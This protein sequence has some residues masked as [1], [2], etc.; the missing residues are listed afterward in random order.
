MS[1]Q[2]LEKKARNVIKANE[3]DANIQLCIGLSEL[4]NEIKKYKKLRSLTLM[5]TFLINN[6]LLKKVT[7][8]LLHNFKAI[9]FNFFI[10]QKYI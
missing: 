1:T 7:Q 8:V 2:R 6:L 3:I 5:N 4:S 10:I 9:C